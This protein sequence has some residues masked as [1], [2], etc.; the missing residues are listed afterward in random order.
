MPFFKLNDLDGWDVRDSA[1]SKQQDAWD[2]AVE[3]LRPSDMTTKI[4]STVHN[5]TKTRQTKGPTLTLFVENVSGKKNMLSMEGLFYLRWLEAK[6]ENEKIWREGCQLNLGSN[7][8]CKPP[9]T[10]I[11]MLKVEIPSIFST[12][13][14]KNLVEEKFSNNDCTISKNNQARLFDHL[15]AENNDLFVMNSFKKSNASR[16]VQSKYTFGLPIDGYDSADESL[17][18]QESDIK[19][20]II[21]LKEWLDKI[22]LHNH[23]DFRLYY[24]FSGIG[25]YSAQKQLIADGSFATGS[26]LFVLFV[27]AFHTRSISIACLGMLQILISFPSTYFFYRLIFQIEHFGT[28]QVLAIYVILGI[29]ADDIFVLYDAFMQAPT[30]NAGNND[31]GDTGKKIALSKRLAWSLRRAVSAMTTTSLTTW[32]AFV[33]TAFSPIINIRCF[34]VFASIMV[35]VNFLLCVLITPCLIILVHTKQFKCLCNSCNGSSGN[36]VQQVNDAGK[37]VI[38]KTNHGIDGQQHEKKLR[39][40]EMFFQNKFAPFILKWRVPIVLLLIGLVSFFAYFASQLKPSDEQIGN[41]W[42]DD[43][44]VKIA[45]NLQGDEFLKGEGRYLRLRVVFGLKPPGVDRTGLSPFDPTKLGTVLWNNNF[46]IS[47][48]LSQKHYSYVTEKIQN[49]KNVRKVDSL[50]SDIKLWRTMNLVAE[51]DGIIPQEYFSKNLSAMLKTPLGARAKGTE[52]VLYDNNGKLKLVSLIIQMNHPWTW[53]VSEK[54][55]ERDDIEKV[56]N[57]VN[58]EAPKTLDGAMQVSSSSVWMDCQLILTTASTF[59][60]IIAFPLAFVI[61]FWAT[62]SILTTVSALLTIGSIVNVVLGIMVLAGW[63]L[64]FMESICVTVIVGL[65]VDYVVHYSISYTQV[66]NHKDAEDQTMKIQD[67]LN[68][69]ITECLVELGV[70]VLGGASSTFGAALFLMMCVIKYLR[71]FGLFLAMTIGSSVILATIMF[72]L[73]LSF[74][75][76]L[77]V[78]R[79][80]F[81]KIFGEKCIHKTAKYDNDVD[82]I[83]SMTV[84]KNNPDFDVKTNTD[85]VGENDN[86]NAID[87]YK[88]PPRVS[89]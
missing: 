7:T 2:L 49:V 15:H 56:L 59:G 44:P 8:I 40:V 73:I 69:A 22:N 54:S 5:G 78:E 82:N 55:K 77:D 65:A 11:E 80:L 4:S 72:P 1:S 88:L 68:N 21:A 79:A 27:M 28:L 63:A 31:G 64:G 60:L 75:G 35:M 25:G 6:I 87:N 14:D 62:K 42:P 33:V 23:D 47:A 18:K 19:K 81:K 71:I 10:I 32:A 41:I 9:K 48:E 86:L 13:S 43:H 36:R 89:D 83:A 39:R 20:Q 74:I 61:V 38:D 17:K 30:F 53:P 45:Y 85:I 67:V 37:A 58:K 76:R 26:I 66:F 12:C 24:L 57:E 46:D 52:M 70:S 29:G 34:G 50:I 51:P 16:V 3:D 84:K